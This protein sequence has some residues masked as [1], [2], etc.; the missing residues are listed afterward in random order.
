MLEVVEGIH[1]DAS[2]PESTEDDKEKE[3][4]LSIYAGPMAQ[5]DP[6]E[7]HILMGDGVPRYPSKLALLQQAFPDGLA[8]FANR[9]APLQTLRSTISL[10][11]TPTS[12]KELE[13]GGWT[14][15]L[16]LELAREVFPLLDHVASLLRRKAMSTFRRQG[17]LRNR[18]HD[19]K[20]LLEQ[21][22]KM[23]FPF[24]RSR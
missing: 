12:R 14:E 19:S 2:W 5:Q 9:R 18:Q 17:T 24:D 13:D 6:S 16:I 3:L 8:V 23:A 11:T 21:L 22:P 20:I 1:L 15:L 10:T 4:Q 7:G